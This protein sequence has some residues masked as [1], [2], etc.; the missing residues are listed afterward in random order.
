MPRAGVPEPDDAAFPEIGMGTGAE[1]VAAVTG[2]ELTAVMRDAQR[3][4]SV[5]ITAREHRAL[6]LIS[7]GATNKQIAAVLSVT[8][9]SVTNI[10]A[11]ALSKRALEIRTQVL[12]VAGAVYYDRL[13]RLLQ[14]WMP[15]ALGNLSLGQ[16]PDEKAANIV[17][18]I[19]DRYARFLGL[20]APIKI[21]ET[22]ETVGGP[23]P[24]ER[25]AI[26]AALL[27]DLA[28]IKRRRDT[29]DAVVVEG[30]AA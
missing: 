11:K 13:E 26:K 6:E 28:E 15:L 22:I 2:G 24:G 9:G 10:V 5:T 3:R 20:D 16:A 21:E 19:L 18:G 17:L 12:P 29:I 23:T 4:R 1:I 30:D 7:V 14:R 27:E 8:P 25:E